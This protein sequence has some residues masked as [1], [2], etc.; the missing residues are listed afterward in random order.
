MER[1]S[2]IEL[3]E[4]PTATARSLPP[5]TLAYIG[6]AYYELL[7]RCFALGSGSTEKMH[8]HTVSLVKATAQSETA[9]RLLPLLSDDELEIFRRGKGAH[10]V[11]PHSATPKEYRSATGLEAVFG[12][13]YLSGQT[14]RAEILFRGIMYGQESREAR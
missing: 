3:K 1:N 5:L 13:L 2:G 8:N 14:Q 11:A 9:K 12:Y 6:D 10:S 7:A 4:N